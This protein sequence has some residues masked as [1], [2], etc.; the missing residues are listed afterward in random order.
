MTLALVPGK[1]FIDLAEDEDRPFDFE[2]GL[3]HGPSVNPQVRQANQGRS[4]LLSEPNSFRLSP[5]HSG[6]GP[7]ES[8]PSSCFEESEYR[9]VKG[10]ARSRFGSPCI[11]PTGRIPAVVL[12]K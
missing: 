2:F 10:T 9:C 7:D 12:P 3:H 5:Y 11:R 1:N 4:L 6:T 8:S